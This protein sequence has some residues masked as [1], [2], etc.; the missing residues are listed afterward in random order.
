M[1]TKTIVSFSDFEKKYFELQ[2]MVAI[3]TMKFLSFTEK[4][5]SPCSLSSVFV[6]EKEFFRLS[7]SAAISLELRHEK[8]MVL[9]SF[10][11]NA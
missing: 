1:V 11:N 7:S 8:H 9:I 4:V 2:A 3:V 6:K 5:N 10:S